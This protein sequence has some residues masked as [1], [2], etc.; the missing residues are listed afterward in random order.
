MSD[1]AIHV[2]PDNPG[3]LVCLCQDEPA[4]S[5]KACGHKASAHVTVA[6][7]SPVGDRDHVL[8]YGFCPVDCDVYRLRAFSGCFDCD[9]GLKAMA[10]I[11]ANPN[12]MM[13][14]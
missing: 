11:E 10:V 8:S 13:P 4:P 1:C 14:A 9:T 7:R 3:V 12:E 2:L 5:C 6:A